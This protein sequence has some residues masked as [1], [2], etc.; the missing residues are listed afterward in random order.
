MNAS[1]S[2]APPPSPYPATVDPSP[3]ES[4]TSTSTDATDIEVD[5]C[6]DDEEEVKSPDIE[7]LSP[8]SQD[9]MVNQLQSPNHDFLKL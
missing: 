3:V 6:E 5:A 1:D 7:L 9:A 4:N 8:A 2:L